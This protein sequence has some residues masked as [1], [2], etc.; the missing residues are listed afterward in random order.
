STLPKLIIKG[1]KRGRLLYA[2]EQWYSSLRDRRRSN[3]LNRI[4][5]ELQEAHEKLDVV[6]G[7]INETDLRLI[8]VDNKLQDLNDKIDVT[9]KRLSKMAASIDSILTQTVIINK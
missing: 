7:N 5:T 2:C 9:N 6:N 8:N 4:L 3:V 1:F